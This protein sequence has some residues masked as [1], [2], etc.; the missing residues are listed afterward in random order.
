MKFTIRTKILIGFALLLL[1]SSLV[2]AFSFTITRQYIS[3]QIDNFEVIEAK[4]GASEIQTFF[5]DLNAISFGLAHSFKENDIPNNSSGEDKFDAINEY[6]VKNNEEIRRISYLTPLGR[7]LLKYDIHGKVPEDELNYEVFTESFKAAAAGK[8]AISKVYYLDK[9]LG[10]HI[11]I[12]SPVFLNNT[13]VIGVIKMQIDLEQLRGSLADIRYGENGFVYVVDEEGRLIAHPSQQYVLERP[14]LSSRSIISKALHDVTPDSNDFTYTNEQ[15]VKVVAKAVKVPGINWVAVF[16]QPESEA[17][18]FLTFIRDLFFATLVGSSII[19]LFIALILSENLTRAI[20]KLEESVRLVEGGKSSSVALVR[21]GDEIE[22]LSNSFSSMVSKLLEREKSIEMEKMETETLLQ[23]LSDAVIALDQQNKII[24]FNRA[25]VKITGLSAESVMGKHIDDIVHFYE[26]EERMPFL[27]YSQQTDAMVR[28]LREKGLN[29]TNDKGEKVTVSIIAN[30][31]VFADQRTG[32]IIAFHDISKEQQLEEMKLDFVSMAAH[33]LRTPLTAIR[34]YAS[35]LE[36]QFG[37]MLD[38]GGKELINR[39][40]ISSEN[41]GNLIDNLLNVS[42]I[43]RNNFSVDTKP[44]DLTESIKSV[45]DGLK[46]QAYTQNQKLTLLIPD[47]LP[48]TMADSFRITQVLVNLVANAIN[49]TPG[50]GSI[51]VVAE[52]KNNF[53]Q[54][55]VS[56]TGEGIPKE[57]L[58][59][60]FTKFFRVSGALEQGSK[61]T[62]LGL[63]ISKSIIEM[64]KG[65]IWVESEAGKGSTFTFILPIATAEEI[66][67]YK[68]APASLTVKNVQGIILKKRQ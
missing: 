53:L 50:G 15:N 17:F 20:R 63:F 39:L 24:A 26:E 49:Y 35:L 40:L 32:W 47:K 37:R 38:A 22:I 31:L 30:P 66:E 43:E 44:V 16:E 4:K 28:K 27:V 45:V 51:T 68:N 25:A 19:L 7:E 67:R 23:S 57:A 13:T 64:H 62:G 8:T 6:I 61:G 42:R 65:K 3:S 59:K 46:Q 34:G 21:S 12:F 29:T 48:I 54:V 41:L 11:D 9:E 14:D 2:L 58:P 55:S 10:P 56:D 5:A 36:M 33:E 1:L 52:T 60:L 18:G